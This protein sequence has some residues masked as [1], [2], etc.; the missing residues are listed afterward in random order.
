M[1]KEKAED[2]LAPVPLYWQLGRVVPWGSGGPKA[3]SRRDEVLIQ[4][5][6]VLVRILT[7]GSG[8]VVPWHTHTGVEDVA[9]C[10]SGRIE[11]RRRNPDEVD[12]L[13]PGK[14]SR[15]ALGR[16]HRV[17][18]PGTSDASYLLIQGV[19]AYDFVPILDEIK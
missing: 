19:G 10:L 17:S 15:T 12:I 13:S 9:V 11:V 4:T 14:W 8:D 18:N 3:V 7:L 2:S 6:D 16:V 1:R 5:T